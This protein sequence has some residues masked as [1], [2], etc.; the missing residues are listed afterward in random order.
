M[1]QGIYLRFYVQ[2]DRKHHHMPV[3][4]W[5]LEQARRLGLHGGSAFKAMAGYGRHG[6][7]H[8][9]HFFELSGKLPVAVEFIVSEAEADRLLTFVQAEEATL[10]Y[11]K[12]PVE[13]AW[14]KGPKA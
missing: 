2:E 6:T 3:Y 4:E 11:L 8:E 14:I 7:L 13:Y 9:D 1:M 12:L 10:F 5:L